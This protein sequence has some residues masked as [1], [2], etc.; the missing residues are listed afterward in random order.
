V[1]EEINKKHINQNQ[2]NK[3]MNDQKPKPGS[4]DDSVR[5]TLDGGSGG[6]LVEQ[7]KTPVQLEFNFI[8]E[9]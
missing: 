3:K 8:K 5:P 2:L 6:T 4:I 9:I 1:V 7:T